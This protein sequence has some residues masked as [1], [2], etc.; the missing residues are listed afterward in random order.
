MRLSLSN[1]AYS[2]DAGWQGPDAPAAPRALDDVSLEVSSGHALGLMGQTGSGKSTLL[3]VMAGLLRP[4]SGTVLL[5]GRDVWASRAARRT[6]AAG[7]GIVFQLPERQFFEPTVT[8]EVTYAL[9]R[10]GVPADVAREKAAES[11]ALLGLDL[12]ALAGRSPLS[13]S[14]GQ[15]RRLA[16]ASV[17]AASP[18]LLLL[19]EPTAGLDP[20]ARCDCLNAIRMCAAAGTCVVMASHDADALAWVCGQVAVLE[21]GRLT[22]CGSTRELLGDASVMRAHGLDGC[23]PARAVAALQ[24]RG[25]KVPGGV[26]SCDELVGR[27]ADVLLAARG[28]EAR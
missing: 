5:D 6:L 1:I 27:L 15:Q 14:G 4:D 8:D 3:E 11:C 18:G 23:S 25:V 19:D 16:V 17:L 21:H 2:Y 9:R 22:L 12:A 20:E 10:R 24:A 26:L 28:R 13:L 7:R